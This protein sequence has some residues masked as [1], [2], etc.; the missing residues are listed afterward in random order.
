M[1]SAPVGVQAA[2]LSRSPAGPAA[3]A[4]LPRQIQAA[5]NPGRSPASRRSAAGQNSA[6]AAPLVV[7]GS[8]PTITRAR[9]GDGIGKARCLRISQNPDPVRFRV[10]IDHGFDDLTQRNVKRNRKIAHFGMMHRPFGPR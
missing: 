1:R 4:V 9:V 7:A 6:T 10:R 2:A 5:S 8:I 3:L